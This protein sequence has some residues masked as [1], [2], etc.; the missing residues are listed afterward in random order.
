MF[1]DVYGSANVSA[2]VADGLM[3]IIIIINNNN[4]TFL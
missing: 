2:A 4:N 3:M 1:M